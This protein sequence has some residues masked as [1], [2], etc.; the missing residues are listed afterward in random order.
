MKSTIGERLKIAIK[1]L[2]LTNKAFAAKLGIAPN[3]VSMIISGKKSLSDSL[4][5]SITKVIPE[6]NLDFIENGNGEILETKASNTVFKKNGVELTLKEAADFVADNFVQAYTES[7]FLKLK[8]EKE[9][10]KGVELR[11]K[12]KGI[13]VKY[14]GPD[15][16]K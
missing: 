13:T 12:E 8:L 5:M 4:K 11:F 9:I 15:D 10:E 2:G 16:R 14:I 1:Q 3:Y 7:E 6:L